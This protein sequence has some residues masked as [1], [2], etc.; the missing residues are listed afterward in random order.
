MIMTEMMNEQEHLYLYALLY[1]S[2]SERGAR[3]V[4]ADIFLFYD[5]AAFV[6]QLRK[7]THTHTLTHEY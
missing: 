1:V 7:H 6:S 4:E 3:R 5:L 2:L